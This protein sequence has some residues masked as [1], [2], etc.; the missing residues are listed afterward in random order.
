MSDD[1]QKDPL[2][3]F[4][5]PS[6]ATA[7]LMA[8]VPEIRGHLLLDPCSGNGAMAAQVGARFGRVVTNDLDPDA[9]A[10]LRVD[11]RAGRLWESVSF[12]WCVTNPPFSLAGEMASRALDHAQHGVALF[13]RLSFLETCKGREFL[14]ADPPRR[15][16]VLPRIRFKGQGTDKV[17]CGWLIWS[18]KP[19]SGPPI[20][21]VSRDEAKRWCDLLGP[22]TA[23]T[24]R[25]A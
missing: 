11:A 12:D 23:E 18:H 25:A 16:L 2:E 1:T 9:A 24:Q 14:V 4:Y 19:L 21:C 3:R 8:R 15:L 6:W 5:T 22:R 17:A 20:V 13:L 7:V 10:R